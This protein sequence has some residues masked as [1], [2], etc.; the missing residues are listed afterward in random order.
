M[1]FLEII[2][3]KKIYFFSI[4]FLLG[5][6]LSLSFEPFKVPFLPLFILGIFFLLNEHIFQ[7]YP[8]KIKIFFFNGIFFGFGFFTF[9]MYWISNSIIELDPNLNYLIPIPLILLPLL[10][11]TFI[12]LMQLA[13]LYLRGNLTSRIFYFSALWTIFEF[14]RSILFTGLPW[15]L[16]GYSWSWSLEFSQIVSVVGIHGLSLITVFCST[17]ISSFI[18][19]HKLKYYFFSSLLIILVIYIFGYSRIENNKINYSDRDIRIVHTYFDQKTKWLKQTIDSTAS[20]GSL[21]ILTIFPETSLGLEDD[22]PENWLFGFIRKDQNK[23]YN[24]I[25]H[26][27]F[28][29][30]KKILVPFGEYFPFSEYLKVFFPKNSFF[31]NSLS[32]GSTEQLFNSNITPLICY[33]AIFSSFVRENVSNQTELLVNISNDA[34]FGEFSGPKQHF[35]HSRFRS[36]ELGIPMVRSSNKGVSGLI[37]PLGQIIHQV[38]S[39]DSE[40]LDVKIPQKLEMTIYK[41]YGNL[42]TYFLIVLFFI[43]GYANARKK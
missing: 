11:S 2:P 41:K 25:K 9:S 38:N 33:E 20:M 15:N 42:F 3:S 19:D 34:W 35:V 6:L 43:I 28:T 12:G 1:T 36:I 4:F 5:S 21:D 7:I 26:M 24:S 10:L 40:Y 23:Y 30:D 32:E 14:L 16:L 37:S 27:G 22:W 29:Y 31:N 18:F 17:C 39:K 8:K 13:N